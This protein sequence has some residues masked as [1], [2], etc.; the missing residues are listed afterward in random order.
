MNRRSTLMSFLFL[1]DLV[2][3]RW[4]LALLDLFFFGRR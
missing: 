1:R 3:G 4:L 2:S